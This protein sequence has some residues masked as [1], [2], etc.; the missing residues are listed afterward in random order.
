MRG[1]TLIELL[2]VVLIIGILSSVALPE[3]TKAVEKSYASEALTL[4]RQLLTAE[5]AYKWSSGGFTGDLTKLDME[6]PGIK[7]D[8]SNVFGTKNWVFTVTVHPLY[9]KRFTA[10]A[11]RAKEGADADWY[12]ILMSV[13][14]DGTVTRKCQY[15][16]GN[17]VVPAI[18]KSIS[19]S[20]DGIIR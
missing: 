11:A 14:E 8:V 18:C 10:F 7:E 1:F 19:G 20:E 17:P 2:V 3:Y 13:A 12:G 15:K 16:S 6:M 9:D 4:L 5:K